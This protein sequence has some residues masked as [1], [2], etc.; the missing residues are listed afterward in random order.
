MTRLDLLVVIT[1]LSVLIW[2]LRKKTQPRA[3]EELDTK[4]H[5]D[6]DLH[7]R[8]VSARGGYVAALCCDS[9]LQF[10]NF[11]LLKKIMGSIAS[12]DETTAG[13]FD[14]SPLQ[15]LDPKDFA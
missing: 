15:D 2:Q 7:T 3:K 5:I 12:N 8:R 4:P 1:L 10:H 13:P 14:P 6:F 11:I 9:E